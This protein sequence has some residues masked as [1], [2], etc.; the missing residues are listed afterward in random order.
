[1]F[2]FSV[3]GHNGQCTQLVQFGLILLLSLFVRQTALIDLIRQF[4]ENL[5]HL[6]KIGHLAENREKEMSKTNIPRIK[7]GLFYLKNMNVH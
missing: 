1:M 2:S 6:G 4:S 5:V 7:M 3:I